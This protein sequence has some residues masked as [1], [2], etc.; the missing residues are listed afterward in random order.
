[1]IGG[2]SRAATQALRQLID[3]GTLK[4]YQQDLSLEV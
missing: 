3:A 4:I 1:M 2:L